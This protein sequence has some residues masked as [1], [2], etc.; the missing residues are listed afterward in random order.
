MQTTSSPGSLLQQRNRGSSGTSRSLY[1]KPGQGMRDRSNCC[2]PHRERILLQR[3][4]SRLIWWHGGSRALSRDV[5]C[6]CMRKQRTGRLFR[7]LPG[8][9]ILQS[10]LN[11]GRTFP[12]ILLPSPDTVFLST[13]T[14]GRDSI[15][16][17]RCMTCTI[18]S[19]SSTSGMM[20]SALP[21]H[22]GPRIAAFRIPICS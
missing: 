10:S 3:S 15:H 11:R 20:I 18:S 8:T 16:G 4:G 22:S 19:G 2:S 14:G 6:R 7:G 9:A 1:R 5:L 17:R 12:R 21:E 13:C